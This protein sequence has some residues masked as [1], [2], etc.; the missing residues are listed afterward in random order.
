MNLDDKSGDPELDALLE[1][2]RIIREVPDV[3]RARVLARARFSMAAAANAAPARPMR[4]PGLWLRIAV[5]A[6]V[7]MAVGVAAAAA[8][9]HW[10]SARRAEAPLVTQQRVV[11]A[12]HDSP[13]DIPAAPGVTSQ[14]IPSLRKPQRSA[15]MQMQAQVQAQTQAGQESYAAEIELLQR[16]QTAYADGNF[17]QALAL[18]AKH[19]RRFPNGRL[20]EERE[21]L[22][23]RS[24]VGSGQ[25]EE[26]GRVVTAF[27][28]RFPRSVLLPRLQEMTNERK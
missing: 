1:Q 5:T 17:L 16:A 4:G 21:G 11:A 14:P 22:R 26:A 27:T 20:A 15:Q 9:L 6:S 18:V 12:V 25:T 7:A 2:G 8:A 13:F 19:G 28:R 23:V 10:Q 3:V 24:L